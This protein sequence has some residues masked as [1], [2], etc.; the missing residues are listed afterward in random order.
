MSRYT[1][2]VEY[3]DCQE[4]AVNGGTLIGGGKLI[5]V[6]F[7]DE[8]A[9]PIPSPLSEW[10]EDIGPVTWFCWVDGEWAAEPAWIGRPIDSD[11]PGYHTHWTPQPIW[12]AD[13]PTS[14][15][16]EGE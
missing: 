4:P 10:N 8:L 9:A 15:N 16:A 2:V 13:L 5:A 12:P 1:Y 6:S 3:P 11:W 7:K 14:T